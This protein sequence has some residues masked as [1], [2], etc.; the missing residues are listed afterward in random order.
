M[1][2]FIWTH[3]KYYLKTDFALLNCCWAMDLLFEAGDN[4]KTNS[5]HFLLYQ[6]NYNKI[7]LF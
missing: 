1:Y 6:I 2:A 3:L 7:L 5:F 4:Y